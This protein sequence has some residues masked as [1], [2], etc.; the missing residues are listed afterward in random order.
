LSL[1]KKV[2]RT[3]LK[4]PRGRVTLPPEW[5]GKDVIV[6]S[7]EEYS[8][9]K[10]RDKNFFLVKTIFQEILNS[11][12]N[13]RR[14]FNVVTKTWNPVSGCLHH[15]SYC[16]A[17]K[18]ANTKLKNSHRYKEGFK[19][20]LNEEE[21]KTRFKDGDF[22]FVSDMGD[23]FG[24]FIPH[25]WILKVLEHIQHFPKTFF[26]FLT[27]N[28]GRYEKFLEDM[29]ENAI[30]GAT[31]ETNRDKLYLE[32]VISGA[33]LPSIRYDAMKKLKWD[34]KFISVEPILDFDLEVLCKWVKDISPF[35]MYVGYDNYHNRLPEPPLS[36]TLKFLEEISEVTLV[37][38]KTIKPAWFERLESHLDGIQ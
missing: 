23:L 25:E 20:R 14:M 38:R 10:K 12:S 8:Y 11:K 16:W 19:P 1:I 32:N 34:K 29:P 6:L 13:G 21:F 9:W 28:P 3:S 37:V 35:M 4:R 33:A 18:L 2:G 24:D 27:K 31:I 22:V 5:I 26:L 30:L 15:C 7:Q 17:R 36:K